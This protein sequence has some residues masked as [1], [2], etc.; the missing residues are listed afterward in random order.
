VKLFL[1]LF[2]ERTEWALSL[3]LIFEFNFFPWFFP[4]RLSMPNIWHL[5]QM[6]DLDNKGLLLQFRF[7][8]STI[9]WAFSCSQ[10]AIAWFL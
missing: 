8:I 10:L 5:G 3:S 9:F 1:E 7:L 2:G 4:S 6:P